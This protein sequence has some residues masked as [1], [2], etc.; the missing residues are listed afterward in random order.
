MA[1]RKR[2]GNRSKFHSIPFL[3][4]NKRNL[5]VSQEERVLAGLPTFD[6]FLPIKSPMTLTSFLPKRTSL[7]HLVLIQYASGKRSG[8][9]RP[10]VQ[11]IQVVYHK[12]YVYKRKIRRRGRIG[13]NTY[14]NKTKQNQKKKRWGA[15]SVKPS[16]YRKYVS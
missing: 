16:I 3:Y 7:C 5:V 10:K 14:T 6:F 15:A 12:I 4:E 9:L 2:I 8:T 13:F 11:P 1:L